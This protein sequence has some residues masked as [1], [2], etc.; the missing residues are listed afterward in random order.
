MRFNLFVIFIFNII[1]AQT[2]SGNFSQIINQPIRL[3][4]FTGL[5]TYTISST[6]SDENG[7]FSLKYS[8]ADY[9][10]AYL[11]SSDNKPLFV[12]LGG[13]N[14]EIIGEGLSYPETI[15]VTNMF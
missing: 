10:V 14:I 6:T 8:K 9:G 7:N 5:K 12:I 3:E 1:S 4:G 11:M 2:I 13:E 15:K